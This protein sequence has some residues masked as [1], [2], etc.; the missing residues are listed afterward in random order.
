MKDRIENLEKQFAKIN[1]F[2]QIF[3][4]INN[5]NLIE[6]SNEINQCLNSIKRKLEI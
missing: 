4:C 2:D 3:V 6:N 1:K 5:I